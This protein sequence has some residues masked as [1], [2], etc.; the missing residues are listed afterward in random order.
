[1]SPVRVFDEDAT[2]DDAVEEALEFGR[3]SLR[4]PFE[5]LGGFNVAIGNAYGKCH[6]CG[7]SS[8]LEDKRDEHVHAKFRDF[9]VV[10]VNALFFH[11]RAADA[12]QGLRSAC[13]SSFDRVLETLR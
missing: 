9:A 13:H 11:P 3:L 5:R 1:M 12:A 6:A 7:A 2:A 4:Q 8:L 10:H